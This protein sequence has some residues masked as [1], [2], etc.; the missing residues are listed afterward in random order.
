MAQIIS[1][2]LL[3]P[4]SQ[5]KTDKLVKEGYE[6]SHGYC[7]P[8][9]DGQLSIL[10]NPDV[11]VTISAY[12]PVGVSNEVRLFARREGLNFSDALK[13]LLIDGLESRRRTK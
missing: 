12:L 13:Q 11:L 7:K 2:C 4:G 8:C 3:C 1:V 5:E 10:D 6:V 9:G